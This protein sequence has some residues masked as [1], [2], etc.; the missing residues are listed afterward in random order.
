MNQKL[1]LFLLLLLS[2]VV[3]KA[4][5]ENE[6]PRSFGANKLMITGNGQAQFSMDTSSAKFTGVDFKP[7]LLWKLSDRMFVESEVEIET[8][9]GVADLGL[10]Y[11]NMCYM[12]NP[13]MIVHAGRFLPKFGAYRGKLGEAFINRFASDPVGS[14]DG[15]I[16]TMD[17]VGAGLLGGIPLGSAKMN[18]DLWVTNGPNLNEDGSID[19][20]AYADINKNK[21]VGGRIGLLPFSNSSLELGFS[22]ENA[23]N[24]G[25]DYEKKIGLNMMAVDL[26]YFHTLSPLK[27]TVRIIGE[28]KKQDSDKYDYMADTTAIT[29]ALNSGSSYY[30]MISI[31]PTGSEN[32]V[33]R[34]LEV[35]ARYSNFELN[36]D[37]PGGGSKTNQMEFA[38]DY[39]LKWNSVLKFEWR[40]QKDQIGEFTAQ[41]VYGF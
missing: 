19:Y 10:E 30:G 7:I 5:S 23:G 27:S 15:G 33:L 14:G 8:G 32:K 26:N 6:S 39:W 34:N 4:Q 11:I 37:F 35:A 38:L 28:Y 9:D 31:R 29:G 24:I 2:T 40:Q 41:L 16:G 1:L 20:E 21:A 12:L 13:Y 3:L 18:Y 22:Y 17:E 36:K 25:G